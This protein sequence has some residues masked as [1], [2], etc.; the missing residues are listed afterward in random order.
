M[1]EQEYPCPSCGFLIF[2]EPPGSYDICSIC[3]WEDDHVQLKYPFMTGGANGGSLFDYQQ[4]IIKEIPIE[5]KENSGYVR[6]SD[7]YPLRPEDYK[8]N[9]NIPK[10]GLGYFLEAAKDAPVYYW[11]KTIKN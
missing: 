6:D 5:V 8:E 10:S 7:W 3:G 4:D 2:D 1:A 9:E 11:K